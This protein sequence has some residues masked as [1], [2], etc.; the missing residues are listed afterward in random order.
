MINIKH[1]VLVFIKT[2]DPNKLLF[3]MYKNDIDIKKIQYNSYG[4]EV[5]ID[6]N[7]Y[8]KLKKNLKSY[9]FKIKSN[10]GIYYILSK[11]KHNKLFVINVIL[12]ITLLYL[13]SNTIISV[14]VIHSK[15][16]IRDIVKNSLEENGIKRLSFKKDYEEL[17]KIKEKILKKY[18]KNIE[19]LEIQRVGMTYVVRV[20]ERIITDIKKKKKACNLVAT[21]D[22][23]ITSISTSKGQ[24]LLTVGDYVK[25]GDILVSG[26]IKYNEEIKNL[27]C[28]TGEVKAEVWYESNVKIPLNY[29]KEKYTG[30]KRYNLSINN[31]KIFKSRLKKY[32]TNKKELFDLL[33]AKIYL[34]T[35]KEILN[36]NKR[37]NENEAINKALELTKEKINLKL[38][39]KER[40]ISQKVLK[41]SINNST[42]YI[43]IFSSVEEII[44]KEEEFIER[45][46]EVE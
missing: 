15:K 11:I 8:F 5:E 13:F 42:M 32:K 30:K 12:F 33:G 26:E 7:D 41:K 44:S 28:A 21:K 14:K 6:I 40:I 37:Y 2:N 34:L 4:I 20:E 10:K 23:I 16:Y 18:P 25:K 24:E 17:T 39:E 46:K 27:V 9:K 31:N 36:E 1:N 3:K 45:K 22:G 29:K 38:T 35:E 19:W 43:E